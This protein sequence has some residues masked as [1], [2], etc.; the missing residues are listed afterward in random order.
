MPTSSA[1][2]RLFSLIAAGWP[3]QS[4]ACWLDLTLLTS[5]RLP[6][7]NQPRS[8]VKTFAESPSYDADLLAAVSS[9]SAASVCCSGCDYERG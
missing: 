8:T 4:S 6:D 2:R 7:R 9:A 1:F 3:L 5:S